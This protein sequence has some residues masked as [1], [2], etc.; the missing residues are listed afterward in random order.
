MEIICII[1]AVILGLTVA[2]IIAKPGSVYKN[3]VSE[4]NPMEGKRVRFKESPDDG[5]NAEGVRGHLEADGESAPFGSFY[6]NVIKRICDIVI[7]GA[8]LVILSPLFLL[9]SLCIFIDDPGKVTFT[10]KRIGKNKRYFKLH[11]F[12]SMKLS[13]PKDMPTHMLKDSEKYV[14]KVGKMIRRHSLDELPQI[15]DIFLGN[16]SLIGP[17]PALWNQ[18]WLTAER[19]RYGANDVMPGLTGW[20][21]INGRDRLGIPEKARLDGEYVQNFGPKMDLKCFFRSLP[22]LKSDKDIVEGN[23][24]KENETKVLYYSEDCGKQAFGGSVTKKRNLDLLKGCVGEDNVKW[25]VHSRPSTRVKARIYFLQRILGLDLGYDKRFTEE[26]NDCDIVFFDGSRDGAITGAMLKRKRCIVFFHNVEYVFYQLEK[27]NN[28]GFRERLKRSLEKKSIYLYERRLCRNAY[29]V[30]TLNE[31]DS[32]ELMRLYGRGSDLILPSSMPDTYT[33]GEANP[34][35]PY[36][37]FVGCDFFGNT[38]GL[39]WFCENCMPEIGCRLIVVG[40]EMD[41][42]KDRYSSDRISFYGYVDDLSGYYRNAAAMVLPILSGSGMKTKTCEAMMQ[43]KVI[44]GTKESFEGY[45]LSEDC[46]VCE[47]G[48]DFIDKINSYLNGNVRYFSEANRNLY[49]KNYEAGIVAGKFA[50][51]FAEARRDL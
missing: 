27:K 50:D 29:K 40:K 51:F 23:E 17:R 30:I 48:K 38:E 37:L 3:D 7:S 6:G 8:A 26:F 16:M 1:A 4:Q 20:A 10:Q 43:G 42:Y 35:E 46:I 44:F 34:D 41:R 5:V 32:A 13:A 47:N 28:G 12:R 49:L 2:A 22:I 9:I 31:R 21:Q 33:A 15:W 36:I 24:P 18:D 14:T 39:F 45:E 19:D 25:Y 11:K